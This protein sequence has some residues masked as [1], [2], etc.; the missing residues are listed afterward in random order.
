MNTLFY[1]ML[2]YIWQYVTNPKAIMALSFFV[3]IL[4]MHN[5]V[6]NKVF[7]IIVSVYILGLMAWGIYEFVQ[8]YRQEQQGEI[9]AEAITK[10]TVAEYGK[11]KNK[12]ELHLIN[13]QM[14]DSIQLLR[15]SKLGDKK[16][17]IALYELPW[18][19]VIGNPAAGKSSAI[20]NSG[21]RFPFE[22]THQKMVS[23]GLS[24]TRSCDWFFS[25]D[26]I[27]L[28]TA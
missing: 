6:P 2:G 15:K 19:M 11:Q 22:E 9:L 28:D 13:Q 1:T 23:A 10:D 5:T 3:A 27:L 18:Y 7:W 25:T 12:E 14:K 21:L 4:A 16:G 20:Y 24:G 8:R 26:G 17:S